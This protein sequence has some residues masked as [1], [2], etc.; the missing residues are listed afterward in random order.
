MVYGLWDYGMGYKQMV[1]RDQMM[2][3]IFPKM[4]RPA[5]KRSKNIKE[6][7]CNAK[8]PPKKIETRREGEGKQNGLTRCNKGTERGGC[9]ACPFMMSGHKEVVK[10]VV[11]YNMG[12]K[13]TVKGHINCRIEGGDLYLLWSRKVPSK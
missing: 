10:K 3:R 5:F 13:I 2:G 1:E 12:E 11:I 8:L 9:Y 6:L 4:Q 7:L